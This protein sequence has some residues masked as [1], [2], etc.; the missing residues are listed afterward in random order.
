MDAPS[1][2][3][4]YKDLEGK[5][6]GTVAIYRHNTSADRI[7]IFDA[8][9]VNRLPASVKWLAHNG[10]GY[11]Q[12]DIDAC[13]KRGKDLTRRRDLILMIPPRHHC[14]EYPWSSGRGHRND[15]T[16]SHYIHHPTVLDRRTSGSKW[17]LEK[18]SQ[19]GSRSF[20]HVTWNPWLG[21]HRITSGKALSRIPYERHLLLLPETSRPCP[22]LDPVLQFDG[23]ITGQS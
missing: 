10:A 15:R 23:R 5:H 18:R 21:R 8:E 2:D 12:I 20:S 3:V 19:T 13:K 4:F 7:G 17:P 22:G 14:L 16:V 11:D 9:L 1:R 6:A